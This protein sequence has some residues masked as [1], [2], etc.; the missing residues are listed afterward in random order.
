MSP[1]KIDSV[2]QWSLTLQPV[3]IMTSHEIVFGLNRLYEGCYGS[4]GY[5]V[6][7]EGMISHLLEDLKDFE[8][9][10]GD[11]QSVLRVQI[12]NLRNHIG[13]EYDLGEE[14]YGFTPRVWFYVE[15]MLNFQPGLPLYATFRYENETVELVSFSHNRPTQK[16]I[17]EWGSI[18]DQP[19][20]F[21]RIIYPL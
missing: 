8:N 14:I 13:G 20:V 5:S 18:V 3:F 21:T 11:S 10:S 9:I 6:G 7:P 12:A 4:I 15:K 2:Y 17:C 19:G 16:H 1:H